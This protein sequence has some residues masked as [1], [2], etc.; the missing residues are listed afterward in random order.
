MRYLVKF[1]KGDA[2]KFISHLDLMRTL[3]RVVRRS[4][5]PVDYSNGFNPHMNISIAQPLPVGVC[6]KAEYLDIVL[7]TTLDSSAIKDVLNKNSPTGVNFKDIKEIIATGEKKVPQGM[8]VIDA[9]LYDIKIKYS[10]EENIETDIQK[11]LQMDSWVILKKTKSG[12]KLTNIKPM[13]KKFD[14]TL[15]DNTL[16]ISSFLSCGSRENLSAELLA[17]FIKSNTS[18]VSEDSFTYICREELYGIKDGNF[19]PLYDYFS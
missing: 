9:A 13:V 12:E 1:T 2:I 4:L 5:I 15:K 16:F 7:S 6:S 18:N 19:V 11:L 17:S 3:Q 10:S 14:Y 8:A